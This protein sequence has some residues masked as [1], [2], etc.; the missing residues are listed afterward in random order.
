MTMLAKTFILD[1]KKINLYPNTSL[2]LLGQIVSDKKNTFIL[3]DENIYSIYASKLKSWNVIVIPAGESSKQLDTTLII[4]KQLVEMNADRSAFIIGL[5]GGVV[6]DIAGFV[7]STYMR[8][9]RL[10]LIPTTLLN[11]VDASIGGKN[12]LDVG[13]YKNLVG[14]INQPEF[15]LHDLDFLT[16][17]PESEWINGFAEIIKH[18]F[19]ADARLVKFLEAHQPEEFRSDKELLRSMVEKNI[20]IKFSIVRKDPYEQNIRRWLNFGHTLGHA[21]ENLY[22]LPHGH[23]VAIG[24]VA[25]AHISGELYRYSETHRLISLLEQYHLP[26]TFDFDVAR[27]LELMKADKKRNTHGVR[28]VLLDSNGKPVVE[29]LSWSR[30]KSLLTKISLRWK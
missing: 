3:T 19:I 22:S 6:T 29:E 8:G 24:M 17:L 20:Q 12:G 25:A 28:Y 2:K 18:A 10:G 30:I 26:T 15:I 1:Q 27:V 16:T 4:L 5:G 9:V 11:L 23:A 14:T 21:L 7:A 13:L